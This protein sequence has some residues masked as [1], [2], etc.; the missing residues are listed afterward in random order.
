MRPVTTASS[1]SHERVNRIIPDGPQRALV[2]AALDWYRGC[3]G[4]QP[5]AIERRAKDLFE[6]CRA[7]ELSTRRR[8]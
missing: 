3:I 6:A 5:A 4:H 8:P 2:N 1:I 7:F